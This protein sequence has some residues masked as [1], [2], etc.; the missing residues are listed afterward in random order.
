MKKLRHFVQPLRDSRRLIALC[1]AAFLLASLL[2]A[3]YGC[4]EDAVRRAGGSVR[5]Q[6]LPGAADGAFALRD[7]VQEGDVYTSVSIDPRME[8]DLSS[9]ALPDGRAYV[10]RVTLRADYLNMEPGEVTVFY[11]PRPGMEE[12]DAVYRV[13]AHEEKEPGVYTFTL[14]MRPIYGLRLDPGIYTG[15]QFRLEEIV[16]NEP[17]SLARR[18]T[19]TRPWLLAMAVVPLLAASVLRYLFF[20]FDQIGERRKKQ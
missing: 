17:R 5:Q 3:V 14:P 10:R 16:L 6:A 9:V 20:V 12:Y 4:A 11:K 8:I 7:L 13:W 15:M 19:P 18:L 2:G 1:Y